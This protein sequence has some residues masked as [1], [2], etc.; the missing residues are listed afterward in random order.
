MQTECNTQRIL[1]QELGRREVIV[2]FQGGNITSDAGCLLLGD[3]NR[4]KRVIKQFASCFTDFRTHKRI[5]HKLKELL[6]QRIYGIAL[7]YWDMR[8]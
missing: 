3:I 8:I 4:G 6:A 7:G 1:F 2:D 5:D